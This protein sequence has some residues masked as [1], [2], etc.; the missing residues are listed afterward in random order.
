[1]N[2]K[3][4]QL[5]LILESIDDF[6]ACTLALANQGAQAYTNFLQAREHLIRLVQEVLE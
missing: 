1:M 2:Q 5:N 3:T 6:G 4:E